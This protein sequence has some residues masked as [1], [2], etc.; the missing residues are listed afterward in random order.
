MA[1]DRK[2]E[3][4]DRNI[5]DETLRLFFLVVKK[6]NGHLMKDSTLKH[7]MRISGLQEREAKAILVRYKDF[8]TI[9]NTLNDTASE[10]GVCRERIRQVISK[11]LRKLRQPTNEENLKGFI[12]EG[13][14][15]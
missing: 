9:R 5:G 3:L 7:I 6:L 4:T 15:T 8:H 11:A 14:Q 2:R 13:Q 1:G 12:R 10:F